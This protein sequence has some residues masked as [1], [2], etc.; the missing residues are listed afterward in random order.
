MASRLPEATDEDWGS[1]ARAQPPQKD[2]RN[3]GLALFFL[4]AAAAL[5]GG[6]LWGSVHAWSPAWALPVMY[7][8]GAGLLGMAFVFA[9]GP[10]RLPPVF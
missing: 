9:V 8:G 6:A 2:T 7:F 1:L 10:H 4:L 5:I 3:E